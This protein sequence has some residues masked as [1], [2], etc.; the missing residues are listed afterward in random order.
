MSDRQIEVRWV[1]LVWWFEASNFSDS[2]HGIANP[3][4][5]FRSVQTNAEARTINLLPIYSIFQRLSRI[6]PAK[7]HDI[8]THAKP[9]VRRARTI[10]QQHTPGL[11]VDLLPRHRSVRSCGPLRSLSTIV[12]AYTRST[13]HVGFWG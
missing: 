13:V 5:W 8:M 10:E 4:F 3:S 7:H 6:L 2:D 12:V 11:L 9:R 1:G